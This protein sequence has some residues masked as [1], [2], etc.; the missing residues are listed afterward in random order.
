MAHDFA[1]GAA[2]IGARIAARLRESEAEL[3][4]QWEA[5]TPVRH[6]FLDDLLPAESVRA[7]HADIPPTSSLLHK[8]SL[9]ESKWV[10]VA[11]DRYPPS[12][13]EHLL[14]FQRP[15]VI[16]AIAAITGL[17]QMEADPSL[18]ASGISLMQKGDFLNPHL[19]NSHDGDQRL[20]RV[21]NLLFYVSPDWS[22]DR[23][24]NLEL[25]TKDRKTPRVIESRFN[26]LVVMG[27]DDAS[28][29]SVQRVTSDE[30]RVCFSN[31]YFSLVSPRAYEYRQVTSFR[32]RP[33]EPLKRI[34]LRADAALL[35]AIGFALPF[36]LKR[37]RHR[38]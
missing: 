2:A 36:L 7:L 31:Y 21:L 11:I 33:E 30:P 14:A 24:G 3:R 35:N 27:T 25:W 37:N 10:G 16:D 26:R 12:I 17:R 5:S 28:W 4:A 6:F 22:L 32:G 29:H 15:E 34:V 9:R 13:G 23:G 38:R 18:Y 19:D 8:K 1:S 20:Y